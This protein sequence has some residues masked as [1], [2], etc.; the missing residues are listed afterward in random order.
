MKGASVIGTHLKYFVNVNGTTF[1]GIGFNMADKL[2]LVQ[3]N[4]VDLLF[5]LKKNVFR[6]EE[7]LEFHA[8]DIIKTGKSQ[9]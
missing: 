2:Q 3:N 1:R 6:G 4:S 9:Q 5:K 8:V 7:H